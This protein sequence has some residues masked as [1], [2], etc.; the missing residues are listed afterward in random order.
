LIEITSESITISQGSEWKGDLVKREIAILDPKE[1][2]PTGWR[3]DY[4]RQRVVFFFVRRKIVGIDLSEL[5][6]TDYPMDRIGV[7][8]KD[9]RKRKFLPEEE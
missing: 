4:L 2:K 1:K 5:E 6:E 9:L 7:V 3:Y 8:E